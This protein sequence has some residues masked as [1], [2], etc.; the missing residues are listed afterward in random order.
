LMTL[1]PAM[2]ALAVFDRG[3]PKLL[4]PILVFGR[5]P[6]FFYILHFMLIHLIAVALAYIRY[7]DISW[8]LQFDGFPADYGY[9]LPVIYAIWIGVV[10]ALYLPCRWFAGVKQR[11]RSAWLSYL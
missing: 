7:S 3:A 10:A 9:S 6:L 1:G 4:R 8:W 11:N 5:V 2:I